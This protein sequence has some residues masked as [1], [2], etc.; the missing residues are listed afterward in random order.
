LCAGPT[1]TVHASA[2]A[3]GAFTFRPRR[4]SDVGGRGDR[5]VLCFIR[6]KGTPFRPKPVS[7]LQ[8]SAASA[9]GPFLRA[10]RVTDPVASP[11][12]GVIGRGVGSVRRGVREPSPA[13]LDETRPCQGRAAPKR[14]RSVKGVLLVRTRR[15]G[16]ACVA[17][18]SV[19]LG[20]WLIGMF[21]APSML[22]R[23]T[24]AE[25]AVV[26]LLIALPGLLLALWY[27]ERKRRRLAPPS[28]I[29]PALEPRRAVHSDARNHPA[30]GSVLML[31][32]DTHATT[33]TDRPRRHV[34]G[35]RERH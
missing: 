17:L 13:R 8:G 28:P 5:F 32:E 2:S 18:G 34:A 35:R 24:A 6:R 19:G 27:F 16:V 29:E 4:K 1:R 31:D 12:C 20:L 3:G 15:A 10:S 23:S 9:A 33:R 25:L 22:Y 26:L 11:G 14:D 30:H 7:P 21:A